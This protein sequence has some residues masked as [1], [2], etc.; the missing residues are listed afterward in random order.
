VWSPQPATT[1]QV[2]DVVRFWPHF[3]GKTTPTPHKQ[4]LQM[5]WMR[6]LVN[7]GVDPFVNISLLSVVPLPELQYLALKLKDTVMELFF[8]ETGL[9][10]SLRHPYQFSV[11]FRRELYLT[12][13][14]QT[15]NST[16]LMPKSTTILFRND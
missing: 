9:G 1:L 10:Y 14:M 2:N 15:L 13:W 4:R 8:G 5:L 16:N 3:P 12:T 7:F 6:S 11:I